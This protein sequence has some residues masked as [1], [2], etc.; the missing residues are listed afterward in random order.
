MKIILTKKV[1]WKKISYDDDAE[2]EGVNTSQRSGNPQRV[3]RK[4]KQKP[5]PNE[6]NGTV[7]SDDEL[8]PHKYKKQKARYK[9]NANKKND[10]FTSEEDASE[11]IDL[12]GEVVKKKN[13]TKDQ[14]I[15]ML[16]NNMLKPDFPEIKRGDYWDKGMRCLYRFDNT[17]FDRWY[18]CS[19]C[20]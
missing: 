11:E 17:L 12:D 16:D 20:Q 19:L 14:V 10:E 7:S 2:D 6:E 5:K 13:L 3:L 8:P 1:T 9:K 15:Y 4:K 18:H